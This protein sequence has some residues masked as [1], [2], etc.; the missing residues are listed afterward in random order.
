MKLDK[1]YIKGFRNFQES[2]INFNDDSLIIGANDVGKTN[3]IYALRILLDRG[4]S[5]YDLELKES[6]YN[7]YGD[8]KEVTI[9]AH[10]SEI[11]EDCITARMPGKISDTGTLVIQYTSQFSE[12]R[13]TYIFLQAKVRSF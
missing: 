12:G 5:D 11:K 10:F 8:A 7:V 4:F 3:L 1:L 9:R 2:T 6:D 13:S